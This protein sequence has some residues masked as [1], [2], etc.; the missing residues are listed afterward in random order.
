VEIWSDVVCPWCFIGKRRF[1]QALGR[2]PGHADVSVVYRPFQLDPTAPPGVATPVFDVCSH[3]FGGP[4]RAQELIDN[5]TGVAA[6]AGLT[7]H[8]DRAVRANT[9]L[10]H[11]VLWLAEQR[12]VQ[13][14]VKERLLRGYFGEGRNI[15]D[16][17]T[18]AEL[19]AEA[20]LDGTEVLAF[21]DSDAGILEVNA[22][23]QRAAEMG[24]TAVPTYVFD[25]QWAVPGAQD[26]VVFLRVLERVAEME[27]GLDA[28]IEVAGAEPARRDTA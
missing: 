28:G 12:G 24:I 15:G 5:V 20:G 2:F 16:P 27:E 3:K 18:L 10:A 13:A 4:E 11:R 19:A 7:F 23:L 21:L 25:G 22:E 8:L 6:E 17:D 1:E 26:P 14:A 9:M